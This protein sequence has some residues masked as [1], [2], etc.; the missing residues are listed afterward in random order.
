MRNPSEQAAALT[1]GLE[2]ALFEVF[3]YPGAQILQISRVQRHDAQIPQVGHWEEWR[4]GSLL[5]PVLGFQTHV[6]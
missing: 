4:E 3:P 1:L 2:E 6:F 5:L